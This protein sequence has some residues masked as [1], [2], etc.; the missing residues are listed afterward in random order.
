MIKKKEKETK[1]RDKKEIKSKEK[2]R[3]K[4]MK[5]REKD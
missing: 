4:I 2:I 3:R 1:E 5:E